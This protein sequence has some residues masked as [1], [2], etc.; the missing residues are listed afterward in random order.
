MGDNDTALEE[1]EEALAINQQLLNANAYGLAVNYCVLET[2]YQQLGKAE[3]AQQAG[4]RYAL[5]SMRA[6]FFSLYMLLWRIA[7]ISSSSSEKYFG[8]AVNGSASVPFNKEAC[9]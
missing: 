2:I 9:G 1:A 7:G 6:R 8:P 4:M 3:K 5:L